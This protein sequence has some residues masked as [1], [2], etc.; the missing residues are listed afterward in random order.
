MSKYEEAMLELEKLS[1][2]QLW[3]AE[4]AFRAK[5]CMPMTG[6]YGRVNEKFQDE[7]SE[8][9]LMAN[10]VSMELQYLGLVYPFIQSQPSEENE[11]ISESEEM[12]Q[13]NEFSNNLVENFSISDFFEIKGFEETTRHDVKA[14]EYF[15]DK[16][17][18]EAGLEQFVPY[19]HIGCTSEDTNNTAYAMIMENCLFIWY[20]EAAK[21]TAKLSKMA[22]E[23]RK[24]PMLGHTHGQPATPLTFGHAIAVDCYRLR[25]SLKMIQTLPIKVKLN[26]AV[27]N[28]AAMK[29][30]YPDKDWMG[31]SESFAESMNFEH[32][33]ISSQIENHDYMVRFFNEIGLFNSIV[34]NI[35]QNLWDYI[36]RDYL[37]QISKKGEIGSSTMP[38]KTNPIDAENAWSNAET[39][40]YAAI[41]LAR[42][43]PFSRMQRDLSDSSTQRTIPMVFLHSYQAIK[44]LERMLDRVEVNE[45]VMLKDLENNPEVLSE[46]IQTVLRKNG[47]QNAYEVMKDMTRGKKVTMESL[48]EFISS[49]EISEKDK[50]NLLKLEPKT[51]IGYSVEYVEK[52]F[53]PGSDIETSLLA[54]YC[55]KK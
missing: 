35:S 26:G 17:L 21:L 48:R 47:Y 13:L 45:S 31:F 33:P 54:A 53:G 30:A 2:K 29:V 16:K 38:H 3:A 19:V 36:S 6:R 8:F 40:T 39:S 42:K 23:N 18:R 22:Y 15:I 10:R 28:I 46:A 44:S 43:L 24:V 4:Q 37:K 52:Y 12:K 27:G 7:G 25:E 14:V 9:A 1:E 51:Y 55:L 34:A 32:N 49:L 50:E 20:E 5:S 41:G 11:M